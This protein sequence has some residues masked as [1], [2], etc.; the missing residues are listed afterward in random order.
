MENHD[1]PAGRDRGAVLF[2]KRFRV[3]FEFDAVY[4]AVP[5]FPDDEAYIHMLRAR[6]LDD[7][8]TRGQ[9]VAGMGATIVT[10]G[11]VLSLSAP[12]D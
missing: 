2:R 11:A 6:L 10:E 1:S 8:A 5:V 9:P 7:A 4:R 3:E 12:D